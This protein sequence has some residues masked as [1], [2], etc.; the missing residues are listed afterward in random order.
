M[1]FGEMVGKLWPFRK[2]K[3]EVPAPA[4]APQSEDKHAESSVLDNLTDPRRAGIIQRAREQRA[5]M[6]PGPEGGSTQYG[7]STLVSDKVEAAR[8]GRKS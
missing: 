3:A 5:G 1:E 6:L 8:Q 2:K 4:A 7:A